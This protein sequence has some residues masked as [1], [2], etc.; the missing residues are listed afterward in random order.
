MGRAR[1]SDSGGRTGG[2]GGPPATVCTSAAGCGSNFCVDGKC[3]AQ[4]TR[5][6][7]GACT[8]TNGVCVCSDGYSGD[9]CDSESSSSSSSSSSS[10][11]SSNSSSD[12]FTDKG[13]GAVVGVLAT[14]AVVVAVV[15]VAVAVPEK[16]VQPRL[17]CEQ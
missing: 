7:N 16:Y 5:G 1:P 2:R 10:N 11:S 12:K 9:M 14:V 13:G 15:A 17:C 4:P 3:C 6:S 8:G